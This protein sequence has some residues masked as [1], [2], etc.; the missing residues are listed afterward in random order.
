M[1]EAEAAVVRTDLREIAD[2]LEELKEMSTWWAGLS[3]EKRQELK[4]FR[5]SVDSYLRVLE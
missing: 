1:N 2:R 5:A 3:Q 4:T